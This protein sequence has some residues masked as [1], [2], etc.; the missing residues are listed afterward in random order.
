MF[1]LEAL[2]INLLGMQED[3]EGISCKLDSEYFKSLNDAEIQDGEVN[4]DLSIRKAVTGEFTLS[5]CV[6]GVVTIQCDRCLDDMNQEIKG[7]ATY[8]VKLGHETIEDDEVITVDEEEGILPTAWL[9]YETIALAIPIK[10]V[11][12]PGKCNDAM[13]KK[14]EELSATRSGDEITEDVIDPR[15]EKLKNLK[16]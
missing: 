13:T 14:L 3:S 12:A 9:I 11:H 10:H 7:Q 4:L 16:N 5:Y 15:W 6:D 1:S 8:I 2:N